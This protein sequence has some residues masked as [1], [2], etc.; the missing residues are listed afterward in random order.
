[1]R[2]SEA[3]QVPRH[4]R[5]ADRRRVHVAGRA[6]C[7]RRV[8][9]TSGTASCRARASRC[10]AAARTPHPAAPRRPARAAA[11]AARPARGPPR[12]PAT[13]RGGGR[14]ERRSGTPR[15]SGG[16]GRPRARRA[17]RRPSR[18]AAR[19]GAA[20]RAP[21]AGGARGGRSSQ[22]GGAARRRASRQRGARGGGARAAPGAVGAPAR[23]R[24]RARPPRG[25]RA[26]GRRPP[27]HRAPR[28]RRAHCVTGLEPRRRA[29]AGPVA[30]L[31][32]PARASSRRPRLRRRARARAPRSPLAALRAPRGA[33]RKLTTIS[34]EG[35]APGFEATHRRTG[36][37]RGRAHRGISGPL[38]GPAEL[39]LPRASRWRRHEGRPPGRRRPARAM[40]DLP[41]FGTVIP[42]SGRSRSCSSS[43][44]RTTAAPSVRSDAVVPPVDHGRV[45]LGINEGDTAAV[46]V[47]GA[48]FV[49][50]ATTV[51]SD[52]GRCD[53]SRVACARCTDRRREA[54][55]DPEGRR[56]DRSRR[57][58]VRHLTLRVTTPSGSCRERLAR[59]RA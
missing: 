53:R 41:Q 25:R 24:R 10:G 32:P 30:A 5:G 19:A 37:R 11:R 3:I 14:G 12:A 4:A 26:R 46:L 7:R 21:R 33:L 27:A 38:G 31:P 6:P 56:D 28:P 49:P 45:A 51:R 8:T 15:R 39:T 44:T 1:M 17:P 55:R 9:L 2:C 58:D 13:G 43:S 48:N 47:T 50:G 23:R 34:V 57:G 22:G 35:L 42:D 20:A 36:G 54:R 52:L 29:R 18:A 59:A 40:D 16:R